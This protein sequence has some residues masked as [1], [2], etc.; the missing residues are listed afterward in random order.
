MVASPTAISPRSQG[1]DSPLSFAQEQ[2]WFLDQLG[3]GNPTYNIAGTVRFSG[4]LDPVALEQALSALVCRHDV[5]RTTF[6]AR[7]GQPVQV[8]A[9]IVALAVPFVDLCGL[10]EGEREGR[11]QELAVAEARKPFDLGCGPLMRASLVRLGDE[12]HLLLL[13]FHHIATDGW[14]MRV[15]VRE[16]A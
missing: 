5:L 16:L 3:P 12:E 9:P 14:S 11:A 4:A 1:R 8:I 6:V 10:P 13:T 15:L 7:A 2:L